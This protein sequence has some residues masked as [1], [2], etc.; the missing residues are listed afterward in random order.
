MMVRIL[1]FSLQT[2]YFTLSLSYL[3]NA[4]TYNALC[5][6]LFYLASQNN[7]KKHTFEINPTLSLVE[8]RWENKE[9]LK[10]KLFSVSFI[11]NEWYHRIW[12]ENLHHARTYDFL[13]DTFLKQP[14]W[15]PIHHGCF[16]FCVC[17]VFVSA[18]KWSTLGAP[19]CSP[20]DIVVSLNHRISGKNPVNIW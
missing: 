15:F 20:R 1:L 6:E 12:R 19:Y 9:E 3:A 18:S 10:L 16:C 7:N 13:F 8:K 17:F 14:W 5:F 2:Q 11:Q 4:T